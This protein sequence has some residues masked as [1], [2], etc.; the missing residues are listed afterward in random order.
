MC[1][2]PQAQ[3]HVHSQPAPHLVGLAV[4]RNVALSQ[5]H[6]LVQLLVQPAAG[7]V[8]GRGNCTPTQ[9]QLAQRHQQVQR[10]RA[11]QAAGGLVQHEDGGVD[12]QLVADGHALALPSADASPEEAPDDGVPALGEAQRQ[13]HRLHALGTLRGA[14]AT[15]QAQRCCIAQRLPHRERLQ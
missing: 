15:R 8:D 7:L 11:V 6:Q 1:C 4:V 2:S 12:Q 10:C 14:H 5:Q 13:Q 3:Q 9:R